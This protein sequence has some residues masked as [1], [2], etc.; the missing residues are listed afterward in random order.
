MYIPASFRESESE[1]LRSFVSR[2]SFATLISQH[3]GEPFA[4]HLPLLLDDSPSPHGTL[5]GHMARANPQWKTA[6]G[7]Q[8]LAIFHGPHAYVSP[9]W[10]REQNV[11]PTWNYAVVHAYGRLSLIDDRERLH[12]VI[13]RT[14]HVYESPR[15]APWSAGSPEPDFTNRLLDSIVGFEIAIDRIEGKWKLSQNHSLERQERVVEG[16]RESGG[17]DELEIA[18]LMAARLGSG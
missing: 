16:L 17:P 14:V 10:Y 8:V 15:P 6:N 13:R 12:D 4:S 18:A 5:L 1:V 11:V 9:S 2:H 7:Q 3:D